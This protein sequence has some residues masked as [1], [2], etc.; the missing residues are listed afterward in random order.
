MT[1]GRCGLLTLLRRVLSSPSP[2]R[3][4][5]AHYSSPQVGDHLFGVAVIV[6]VAV[7]V[8]DPVIVAALGNGNDTV[9]VADTVND[10]GSIS[11][12]SIATIRSSNSVPRT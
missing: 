5:P 11:L 1:R 12:V 2:C 10:Q 4:I 8:I 6:D 7:I 9:V 3:F